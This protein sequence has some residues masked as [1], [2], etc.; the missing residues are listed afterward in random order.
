MSDLDRF[1]LFIYVAQAKSLSHAAAQLKTT[2]ASLS[3]QM[4]RL[5]AELA[6][7]LFSRS[8]YRLSLTSYGETLLS[9]C[10]RLK[11]EL[12][13]TRSICQKFH[14][15]PEGSLKIVAFTY[16][17]RKLI[18]PRLKFFLQRYSKLHLRPQLQT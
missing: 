16:F 9:Q 4:K 17:A 14:E 2:K 3:K 7:D 1:E 13:D 12:D 15:E 8:G 18:F 5:E 10:L 11:R 6:I